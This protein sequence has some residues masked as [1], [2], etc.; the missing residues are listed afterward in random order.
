MMGKQQQR[1]KTH[2]KIYLLRMNIKL[3]DF[4]Q[5]A[6]DGD[7]QRLKEL[8]AEWKAIGDFDINATNEVSL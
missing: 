8:V 7:L 1:G 4:I 2:L 5:A 6:E 3:N